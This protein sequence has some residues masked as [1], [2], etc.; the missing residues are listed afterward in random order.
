MFCQNT[1]LGAGSDTPPAW[2]RIDVVPTPPR[3]STKTSLRQRLTQ[4]AHPLAGPGRGQRGVTAACSPTSTASYPTA[5]SCR[6]AGCG[7]TAPPASGASRSTWSAATDTKTTSSHAA[8]PEAAQDVLDWVAQDVRI[9]E[10][11]RGQEEERVER[12]RQEDEESACSAFHVH[13]AAVPP[14]SGAA[15]RNNTASSSQVS[16]PNTSAPLAPKFG[17]CSSTFVLIT[18]DVTSQPSA[19]VGGFATA[20]QNAPGI[21]RRTSTNAC[22]TPTPTPVTAPKRTTSPDGV[23]SLVE[24]R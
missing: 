16:S 6:C 23:P 20:H 13:R 9:V 7:T 3:E 8:R 21:R 19:Q 15:A 11:S 24:L 2:G 1:A 18:Y 14:T 17:N 4:R 22:A 12:E 10:A 5:R